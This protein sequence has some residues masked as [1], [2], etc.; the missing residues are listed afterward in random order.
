MPLNAI[1]IRLATADDVDHVVALVARLREE[2]AGADGECPGIADL[3]LAAR[4][5]FELGGFEALLA[6]DPQGEAVAVLT[7]DE[8]GAIYA[9]GRFGT[10][11][12][13]MWCRS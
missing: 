13:S 11:P 6:L 7:L 10:S 5:L 3:T 9:L 8:C 4:R 12:S 2:L 1:T